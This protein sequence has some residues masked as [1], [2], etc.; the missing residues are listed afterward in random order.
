MRSPF[1]SSCLRVGPAVA[2]CVIFT[3]G[4]A[5][6]AQGTP[7]DYGFNWATITNAG[8]RPAN[9]AEAPEWF[10]P[11]TNPTPII[12]G[13]VNYEYRI[14]KTEVTYSQ[15]AE[16]LNAYSPYLDEF[17]GSMTVSGL[18]MLEDFTPRP[19]GGFD[20]HFRPAPGAENVAVNPSLKHAMIMANWLHSDKGITR[21]AFRHGAYDLRNIPTNS[22]GL[23]LEA[24]VRQVGARYWIPSVDEWT[25]A[26]FY[27]P[28]RYGLGQEGYWAY[29]NASNVQPIPG[30]PGDGGQTDTG[31]INSPY[32]DVGSFPGTASPW[33]L[34]DIM[35]GEMEWTDTTIDELSARVLG[36][37]RGG[38]MTGM[39]LPEY[40]GRIDRLGPESLISIQSFGFRIASIPAP[41]TMW[42]L[43]FGVPVLL[44]RRRES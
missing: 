9:A 3:C 15:Y 5:A 30:L 4:R 10:N 11:A 13:Q 6:F 19:G 2:L 36:V 31:L 44:R 32:L 37:P 22:N 18:L 34:L 8:N 29:P 23:W 35:G 20:T 42:L 12:R 24:P 41:P 28:N 27:D 17:G 38:G 39:S 26:A 14:T 21:D 7:P 43:S 40:V 33:G 16:F 25:K 1:L